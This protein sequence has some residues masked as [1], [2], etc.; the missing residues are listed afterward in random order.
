MQEWLKGFRRGAAALGSGASYLNL[1]SASRLK[2]FPPTQDGYR[3]DARRL[4]GYWRNVG[5]YLNGATKRYDR[6]KER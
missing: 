1:G 5:D 3:E 2:P 6:E 4:G